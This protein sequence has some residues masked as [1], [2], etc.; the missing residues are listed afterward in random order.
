MSDAMV[1]WS[2]LL[3]ALLPYGILETRT[4]AVLRSLP[5]NL[6]Y[7]PGG[8]AGWKSYVRRRSTASMMGALCWV[9]GI[10]ALSGAVRFPRY[11]SELVTGAEIVF[12]VDA[13][14]SMLTDDGKGSRLEQAR[15]FASR[16]ASAADGAALS[17]V[18]FRGGAV[19]LCPSTLDRQAFEDALRWA[20]PSVTTAAGSD[21]GAALEEALRPVPPAGTVRVLVVL[22]DGNDT[23]STARAASVRASESG[24]QSVFVGFGG[25]MPQAVVD[26]AG[27]KVVDED[28]TPVYTALKESTFRD[29]ALAAHGNYVRADNPEAYTLVAS[30][31]REAS[32]STG[33]RRN[34]RVE[35]DAGPFLALIALA[36]LAGAFVLS[37]APTVPETRQLKRGRSNVDA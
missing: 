8:E 37:S 31:C 17:L 28:G 33:K 2:W 18:A 7:H 23:G 6:G 35:T 21:F 20:G 27:V 9:V 13:S 1:R 14:N 30:L 24:V 15:T 10:L 5:A 19:T 12:V 32:A 22:G 16:V 3:L 11:A 36:A 25:D 34:I 26:A 29:L 4:I